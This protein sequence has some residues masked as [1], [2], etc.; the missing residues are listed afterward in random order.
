MPEAEE[1]IRGLPASFRTTGSHRCA[2][3]IPG[4]VCPIVNF[5]SKRRFIFAEKHFIRLNRPG[6][7]AQEQH[8]T[9]S[10]SSRMG[11]RY[12]YLV[13]LLIFLSYIVAYFHRLC[14]AVIALDIQETFGLSGPLLGVFGS[15]YFYPY[16]AMQIP[17]GLLADSWGPRKAVSVFL[18][19][20][21]VG[22]VVMGLAPTAEWAIAGRV[23]VGLGVSTLFVANFKL[24]AEWF[25]PREFVVMGGVFMAMGGV[26]A[27]RAGTP[28]AWLSVSMGWRMTLVIIGLVTLILALLDYL[29]IRDRPQ[30]KGLPPVIRHAPGDTGKKYGLWEGMKLVVTTP[31]FWPLAVWTFFCI[32]IGFA[33]GG[34]WGGPYLMTVYGMSKPAAGGVL[35]MF[36]LALIVGSPFLSWAANH[37]GRKPVFLGCSITLIVVFAVFTI[38]TDRL[39]LVLLY[40][41]WFAFSLAGSAIGPIAA[42]MAKE[43]F[44]IS[45]AGTSVG[46]VNMFPFFGG[47]LFQVGIGVLVAGRGPAAYS[48]AGF[49]GMFLAFLVGSIISLGAALLMRETLP[50]TERDGGKASTA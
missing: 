44:P 33:L 39:P 16:A 5:C 11:L 47:A 29:L 9:D 49:R 43:L 4:L 13:C 22:S 48:A 19:L 27:L 28:L 41:L 17:S 23:L 12:R 20:A 30:D 25:T 31:R 7:R 46:T 14:P 21:A 36:A 3:L 8:L 37:W 40:L 50:K 6:G 2:G 18:I 15:A 38:F 26:G 1:R 35:S 10:S 45:I 42:A 32:G 34:L 24:L